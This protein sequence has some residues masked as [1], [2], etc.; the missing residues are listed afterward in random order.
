LTLNIGMNGV[1]DFYTLMNTRFGYL[2]DPNDPSTA[3]ASLTFD[4]SNGTM[5]TEFLYGGYN[6]RDHNPNGYSASAWAFNA[7]APPGSNAQQFASFD[8]GNGPVVLDMQ[9]WDLFA[10]S[11]KTLT[12]VTIVDNG[13][14]INTVFLR[15]AVVATTSAPE[16]ASL[17]LVATGLLGIAGFARR[18]TQA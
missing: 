12:S 17:A 15:G 3:Q 13:P 18:R 11:S 16:P 4:Y 8:N 6:I 9:T 5:V 7:A 14:G 2:G 1:L 10:Y